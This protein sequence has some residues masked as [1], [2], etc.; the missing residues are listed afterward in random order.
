MPVGCEW[1]G[2]AAG[3]GFLNYA[4]NLEMVSMIAWSKLC[5]PGRDA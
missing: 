5:H 2:G 3:S 4:N 1:Q